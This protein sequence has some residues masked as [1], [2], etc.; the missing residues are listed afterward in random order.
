L[1]PLI[2]AARWESLWQGLGKPSPTAGF[3]ALT[4]RFAEPHRH[5]HTAQHISECLA[6]FDSS[7]S[8]CEQPLE[9]ELALWFHD[10][11]YEPRA[12]DNEEQSAQWALRVMQEC[13]LAEAAQERVGALIMATCHDALPESQYAKVLVDIDLSMLGA[14][15]TRFDEYEDQV[16]AEYNWVPGFLFRRKRREILAGFLARSTIY[17]TTHFKHQ[18]EKKAR[19][20]L[21]R[22]LSA[23]G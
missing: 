17:S 2:T 22:S 16:R 1:T 14:D 3:A 11:I 18:L 4:A 6:H 10:A 21:A 23:L 12:K 13:N 8:L 5:Y 15:T 19:D 9:V 20:N 7:H